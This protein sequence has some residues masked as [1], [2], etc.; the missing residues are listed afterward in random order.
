MNIA[1]RLVKMGNEVP[2]IIMVC[3]SGINSRKEIEEFEALGMH[4]FLIGGSLM[5]SDNIPEKLKDLLGYGKTQ[6]A[7]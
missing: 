4:A 1:R 6:T 7:G 5:K 2:D 3:E